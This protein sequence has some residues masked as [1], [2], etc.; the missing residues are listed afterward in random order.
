M[1]LGGTIVIGG[2]DF[3]DSSVS[4]SVLALI[5]GATGGWYILAGQVAR[6]DLGILEYA[7]ITYTTAALLLLPFCLATGAELWGYDAQ[8]WWAIVGMIV[9]PQLLG[10]TLINY[11]LADIDATT[12]SVTIMA[13][14]VIA[15]ALAYVLFDEVPTA[16][17]YP[18]AILILAGIYLVSSGAPGRGSHTRMRLTHARGELDLDRCVVMGILN[19]TPDSFFD[20]GRMDLD[21]ALEHGLALEAE[22]AGVIDIGAVK[23]GP[24][25]DVSEDRG[26][27]PTAAPGRA[28]VRARPRY[29]YRSRPAARRSHD[30][31]SRQERRSLTMSP[32]SRTR[33]WPPQPQPAEPL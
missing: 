4:G 6:R 23:A 3:A 18:A 5:G 9:G 2:T 30:G 12:V 24:G 15:M 16:I 17:V 11:V 19:R 33:N 14:P 13:E 25:E 8:T 31:P 32:G 28:A 20:G 22:G 29:R 27:T 21:S 10:H 7:L 26:G 1:A